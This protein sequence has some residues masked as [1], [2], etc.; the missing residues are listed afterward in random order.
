MGL[1]YFKRYPDGNRPDRPRSL[2]TPACR[3]GYRLVAWDESLLEAHAETKYHSFRSEI[4]ANVFPCLGDWAGCHRLM[5]EIR[6]K[7]GFLPGATWL[8]AYRACA[9]GEPSSIAARFKAFAITPGLGRFRTWASRPSIAAGELGTCLL[10]KALRGI[11]AGRP[12][13]ALSWKSRPKTTGR[14]ASISGSASPRRARSTRPS[15]LRTRKPAAVRST[16]SSPAMSAVAAAAI[17]RDRRGDV[18]FTGHHQESTRDRA[19]SISHVTTTAWCWWPSRCMSLESAAFTFLVPAGC[20]LDPPD[21]AGLGSF[22]CEMTL[23]G[24]GPRDSRQFVQDLENLGVER[25]ESVSNSHT[26]FSGATLAKNLAAR[27]RDFRRPAASAAFAGRPARSRRGWSCC[28]NCSAIEDEPGQKVMLELRR[29]QYPDPWGRSSHGE[30]PAL[31]VDRLDRYSRLLRPALIIPTARSWAW[32]AASIGSGSRTRSAGCSAI[33]RRATQ[34]EPRTGPLAGQAR[35]SAPRIEPNA[36]RHRLTT[37]CP[38]GIPTIFRPGE[39]W[40]C[41]AAA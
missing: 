32:P 14:F 28:K 16:R 20:V 8:V 30:Q 3:A 13:A 25:G 36:N 27:A 40:A 19:D 11:S 26:S 1:T 10:I 41:S 12:A 2:R 21:L 18:L 31:R 23:R 6:D 15:R 29:R 7:Q 9:T 22:T 4:D 35:A 24:S 34:P 5:H 37:A 39:P 17:S 38:I 33:G